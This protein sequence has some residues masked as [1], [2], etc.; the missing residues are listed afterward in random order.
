ME[1]MRILW[2]TD[3][4]GNAENALPFV[5][6]LSQKYQAEIH[7]IYVIEELTIHEAWYGEFD[8]DHI[9]EIHKWEEEK[10]KE[11]LN[12]ICEAHLKGC[13]LY[14]RHIAIG[15]PADE[16]LK[17][18]PEEHIDLVVMTTR[19]RGG[20]FSYGSVTEKVTK[21]SPVCVFSVPV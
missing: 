12:N 11:R 13:P 21:N 18:I 4:S 6:S 7:I 8:L 19:G 9:K 10:A 15:D 16:I 3:L 20:K 1:I 5:R 17:L 14:I 2:P